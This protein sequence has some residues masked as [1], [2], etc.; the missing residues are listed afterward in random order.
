MFDGLKAFIINKKRLNTIAYKVLKC[1]DEKEVENI[2]LSLEYEDRNY[3]ERRV[4]NWLMEKGLQERKKI[5]KEY[6]KNV[7]KWKRDYD[8]DRYVFYLYTAL[9]KK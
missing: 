6:K 2:I 9:K 3:V 1:S 5:I 7:P 4:K 8:R